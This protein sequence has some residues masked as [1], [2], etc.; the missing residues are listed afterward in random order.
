MKQKSLLTT[1]L[2]LVGLGAYTVLNTSYS[3]G[4]GS[5]QSSCSCHGSATGST[6]VAINAPTFYSPG[7]SYPISVTVTNTTLN[8]AGFQIQTNIGTLTSTDPDVNIQTGSLSAGHNKRKSMVGNTATFNLT[9]TAPTVGGTAATFNSVGNAVNGSG[10]A[11]DQWN[12]APSSNVALPV[13]FTN[14]SAKQLQSH[15]LVRFE[16]SSEENIKS[17]EIERGLDGNN[18]ASISQLDPS[19]AGTY[20]YKDFQ[21]TDGIQ[22]YYRIKETSNNNEVAYSQVVR[23][24]AIS[25]NTIKIYPTVLE[26]NQLTISGIDTKDNLEV[27]L[28]DLFGR[29]MFSGNLESNVVTIPNNLNTAYYFV[30]IYQDQQVIHAQKVFV[31]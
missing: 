25:G 3:T 6:T 20:E 9:W 4:F 1:L 31:K 16:T 27:A 13:S 21:A 30:A 12:S 22:Y 11:G 17:F 24:A 23:A 14:V 10:T 26:N 18:F 19:G 15:V 7:V 28:F 8:L 2:L 5:Y 29:K